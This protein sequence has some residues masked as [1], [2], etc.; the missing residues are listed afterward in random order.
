LCSFCK[1]DETCQPPTLR[2]C[3]IN[4]GILRIGTPRD[5]NGEGESA[6]IYCIPSNSSAFNSAAGFP[7]PGALI[8][9]ERVIVVG[10][11]TPTPTSTP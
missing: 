1:S 10:V 7:G 5:A 3:F 4:S 11:P 8:Q 9:R 6:G 2:H